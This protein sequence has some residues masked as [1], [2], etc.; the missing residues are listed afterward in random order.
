VSL[1][2]RDSIPRGKINPTVNKATWIVL[3]LGDLDTASLSM[4]GAMKR[5]L[6]L[7][8]LLRCCHRCGD[9]VFEN[10]GLG[11]PLTSTRLISE[12]RILVMGRE[13]LREWPI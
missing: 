9:Q 11:G 10:L 13:S 5:L 1:G 4:A 8:T 12:G 2:N 7:G 6:R 3:L